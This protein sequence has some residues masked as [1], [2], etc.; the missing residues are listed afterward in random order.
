MKVGS[1]MSLAEFAEEIGKKEVL[2]KIEK[3]YGGLPEAVVEIEEVAPKPLLLWAE[4]KG[5][6]IHFH[7]KYVEEIQF[8]YMLLYLLFPHVKRKETF[9]LANILE[10]IHSPI[11]FYSLEKMIVSGEVYDIIEEIVKEYFGVS[12]ETFW[13]IIGIFPDYTLEEMKKEITKSKK[14]YWS[15]FHLVMLCKR[16]EGQPFVFSVLEKFLSHPKLLFKSN[17]AENSSF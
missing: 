17:L 11:D 6:K 14:G 8:F 2:E 13:F 7:V 5:G 1:V 4:K 9:S 3:L 10:F 15:L 12:V 16:M